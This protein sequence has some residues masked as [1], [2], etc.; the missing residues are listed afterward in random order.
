MNE[1]QC[2]R[3]EVCQEPRP[4]EDTRTRRIEIETLNYGFSVRIGCQLFAIEDRKRLL[5]YIS[6]YLENPSKV[7]YQWMNDKKLPDTV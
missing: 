4:I 6:A 1:D 2:E 7:E 3:P 5:Q